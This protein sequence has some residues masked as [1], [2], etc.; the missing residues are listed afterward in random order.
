LAL[1]LV[2]MDQFKQ[3]NNIYGYQAGD[4]CLKKIAQTMAESTR[5]DE[6]RIARFGGEQFA[7]ILPDSDSD[8]AYPLAEKIRSEVEA[9]QI[10]HKGDG[11]CGVVTVSVGVGS[12]QPDKNNNYEQLIA[13]TNQ[14]LYLAKS[15]GRNRVVTDKDIPG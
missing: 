9:L 12:M 4:Q 10:P 3:F 8:A 14:A 11:T 7:V 2:D 13:R 1:I 6:E 5:G 15:Q